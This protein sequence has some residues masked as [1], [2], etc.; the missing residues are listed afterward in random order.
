MRILNSVLVHAIYSSWNK[1]EIE[2]RRVVGLSIH[3]TYWTSWFCL[4]ENGEHRPSES[5]KK[6]AAFPW[7]GLPWVC[8]VRV[9]RA[10]SMVSTA[11]ISFTQDKSHA[12]PYITVAIFEF[13]WT[14]LPVFYIIFFSSSAPFFP[15]A[16]LSI[17]PW[18]R[19]LRSFGVFFSQKVS[20]SNML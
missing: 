3:W 4:M 9:R 14:I 2:K 15:S 12:S 6:N 17:S 5:R 20:Y 1:N 13:L 19:L 10:I 7:L 16:Y 18:F 8:E 11:L